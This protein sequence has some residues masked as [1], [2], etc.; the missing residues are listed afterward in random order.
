[1]AYPCVKYGGKECDG[2]GDCQ[3]EHE[4]YCP[5][6]GELLDDTLYVDTVG[7]IVGC[8]SCVS[9]RHPGEVLSDD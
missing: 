9:I 1:M 8:D 3:K 7:E 4:Y 5:V 2:C 6:C